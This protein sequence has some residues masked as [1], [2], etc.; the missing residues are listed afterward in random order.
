MQD[1]H[2]DRGLGRID[3]DEGEFTAFLE[4]IGPLNEGIG[5]L[6]EDDSAAGSEVFA[7]E[8]QAILQAPAPFPE[9]LRHT[10]QHQGLEAL[11]VEL[12]QNRDGGGGGQGIAVAAAAAGLGAPAALAEEPVL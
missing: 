3:D 2:F 10:R 8:A 9:S 5:A 11:A 12:T 4:A 7:V 1:R 6:K